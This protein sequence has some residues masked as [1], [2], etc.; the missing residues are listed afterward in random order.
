MREITS[1]VCASSSSMPSSDEVVSSNKFSLLML[2][3]R[4]WLL[5]EKFGEFFVL[6]RK[7]PLLSELEV[8]SSGILILL[9][10]LLFDVSL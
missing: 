9:A 1:F 4:P 8:T 2:L 5:L 7:L 6:L 3:W 10:L